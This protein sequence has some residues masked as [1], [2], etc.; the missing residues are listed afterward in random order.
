MT[1]AVS[2]PEILLRSRVPGRDRWNV[3]CLIGDERWSA[4]VELVLRGEEGVLD[5]TA[6]PSTGRVL[7][8][9]VSAQLTVPIEVLLKNA[10]Q[11][12]PPAQVRQP[13]HDC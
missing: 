5:V 13:R 4:A 8:T 6:N 12:G 9:Y 10:L 3:P 2:T 1:S 7:V 11:F